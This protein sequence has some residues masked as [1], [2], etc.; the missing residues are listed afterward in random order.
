MARKAR[1]GIG[2][3]IRS[4]AIAT[5]AIGLLA[6]FVLATDQKEGPSKDA[7]KPT[8]SSA[9]VCTVPGSHPTLQ[10]AADD[11]N[12]TEIVLSAQSYD[13]LVVIART[14]AVQGAPSTI[15]G[16]LTV[17]GIGNTLTVSDLIIDSSIL[18]RI[19]ADGFESSDTLRWSTTVPQP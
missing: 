4:C 3:G 19:F 9:A 8:S 18:S 6:P 10:A 15:E 2:A 1:G 12:C 16:N 14:V 5:T 7:Q 13:E 11:P 17:R